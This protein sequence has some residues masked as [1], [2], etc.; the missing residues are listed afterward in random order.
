M[1]AHLRLNKVVGPALSTNRNDVLSV[2]TA[3]NRLGLFDDPEHGI[4][5]F[6]EPR[7]FESIKR[8]QRAQ[9]LAVD[10]VMRRR[11]PTLGALNKALARNEVTR[12]MRPS[13]GPPP[14]AIAGGIG[15]KGPLMSNAAADPGDVVKMKTALAHLG[16][17]DDP[18]FGITGLPD[19]RLFEGIRKFQISRDIEP[20]G[21]VTRQGPT[22]K[23][24]NAEL[25]EQE[26]APAR[27]PRSSGLPGP[28]GEGKP[29]EQPGINSPKGDFAKELKDL[30]HD[31]DKI[32]ELAKLVSSDR[33]EDKRVVRLLRTGFTP[34][35]AREIAKLGERET[36]D[37]LQLAKEAKSRSEFQGMLEEFFGEISAKIPFPKL[38]D[39][40][41]G[42]FRN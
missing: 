40:A 17:F 2:K 7:M 30:G 21:V 32:D 37:T 13:A 14:G 24:L 28:G 11:G 15:L 10:G 16:L 3:L 38:M 25:K 42:G 1:T 8:F 20:D 36:A 23:A 18:E 29:D 33:P 27:Q 19:G 39:G 22:L 6:P 5:P 41:M 34:E 12:D 9:G 4:T 26:G 35:T 31:E